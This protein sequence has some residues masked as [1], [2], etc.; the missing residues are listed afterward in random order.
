MKPKYSTYM[1]WIAIASAAVALV[2]GCASKHDPV[3]QAEKAD[4]AQGIAA[5]SPAETKSIAEDA[6]IYGLPIVMNYAVMYEYAVDKNGPQFKAP[7]NQI[8][9]EPRVFTYQ[10]TAIVTPNSDT[11]YSFLWM[12]LRAEPM[13]LSVP[14]VDKKRYYSVQLIDGNTYN[15]GY[16]GSRT[17]GNGSGNYMVVGPD[18]KGAVPAGIDKV[19]YSTTPFT[20]AGYRT[21]LFN[22]KDMPNVMKVQ[23]GYKV[24]PL[25]AF[26]GKPAPPASPVINF[27][28]ISTAGI[29]ENFF[30]YLD[31]ALQYV[32]PTPE[33]K[34]VRARIA[35][36]GIGPGKSFEFKDLSL[37]HKAAV[38]LGMKEGDEK[39]D[40]WLSGGL[41][42]VNGWSIGSYFGDRHFYNGD[43]LKRAGGAKGGIY[44]NDA[45]EATYPIT[46]T[47]ATG[48]PMDGS[49][50][51]YTLTFPPGQLPPVNAF[52]SVT[53]YDGKT[54][55]LIK[56]PI[57]RYLL[58][59]PMLPNMKKNADGSLTLYIQ[60]TSPG[61]ALESNW[62]PAPDGPIYLV[63]RLYWPK[64]TPPSV[65]PAGEGTWKP[66]GIVVS[67]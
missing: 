2:S 43:W 13:V 17:T 44:G 19:F 5:P 33:D 37:E 23:S 11:P 51:N 9:N 42:N 57:D 29:K 3:A 14:A 48:E 24:Q 65:L 28:S 36:I 32:P 18:W 54:Q 40:K 55:L 47:T 12:D 30:E 52:W 61:K 46:R 63:M 21:Q 20:V 38:L 15:Y 59:S 64:E 26:L 50:H 16:I 22:P 6:F 66:A 67:K 53:M 35:K 8:K 7:F 41:K 58:N 60:R 10:D 4:E 31:A 49:K 34:E 62:L 56:N 45:V 1:K 25:S 27:S 39:V